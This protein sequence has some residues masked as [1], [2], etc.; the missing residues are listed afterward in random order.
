MSYD[1]NFYAKRYTCVGDYN[2]TYNCSTMFYEA[3]PGDKGIRGLDG[4]TGEQA[5]LYLLAGVK[6][7][8]ANPEWHK[9]HNPSNGWGS[10][11]GA[12]KFLAKMC[13]TAKINPD[14]E[15]SAS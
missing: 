10:Y 11:E 4:M 5:Y 3:L 7:M 8:Q 14:A 1:I 2:Y 9:Q 12:L 6:H 15:I 13:Q